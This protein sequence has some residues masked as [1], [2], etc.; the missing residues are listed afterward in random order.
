[1][2]KGFTLIELLVV[3]A[4]I[5]MLSSV[6]LASLN[7]ARGNA[8]DSR[9]LSDLKTIH[10]AFEL[11]QNALGSYP[12]QAGARCLDSSSC[13]GGAVSGDSA[14]ITA[15]TPYLQAVP[16]DPSPNRG[17]GDRY[18]YVDGNVS[19]GCGAQTVSGKFIVWM[20]DEITPTSDAE[21][22]GGG[23]YA[24]CGSVSCSVNRYCA[25]QIE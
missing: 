11:A 14:L 24:C 10:T 17:I 7:F 5:G 22:K 15:L 13:W 4:I 12:G 23:F 21:C 19:Q 1:M 8:R 20:P 25:Y 18:V 16:E 3:V 2:K 9:R 6:V